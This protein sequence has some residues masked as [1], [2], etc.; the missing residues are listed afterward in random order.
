MSAASVIQPSKLLKEL[1][2]LWVSLG[3]EESGGHGVLRACSMTLIVVSEAADDPGETLAALMPEHPARAIVVR[4]D[5]DAGLS[6]RVYA[7]CW[8]PFG[9]RQQICSEQVEIRTAAAQ[10]ADV[11]S[12]C[13]GLIVPDLP[14][15][16]WSRCPRLFDLPEFERLLPLVDKLIVAT[17]DVDDLPRLARLTGPHIADLSW[18]RL[19]RWRERIASSLPPGARACD[20]KRVVIEFGGAAMPSRA[21]YLGAWLAARCSDVRPEFIALPDRPRGLCAVTLQGD[22]LDLRLFAG[23]DETLEVQRGEFSARAAFGP[24]NDYLLLREE[25]RILGRDAVYEEALRGVLGS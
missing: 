16:L 18:T 6:A 5:D 19:T 1:S 17:R 11:P 24:L 23:E 2:E 14:V 22:G 20:I 13:L 15:V 12:V 21:A 8:M 25:L 7:Q 4:L 3:K 10:L 9:R